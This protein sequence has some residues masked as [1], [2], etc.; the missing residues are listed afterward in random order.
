MT[1]IEAVIGRTLEREDRVGVPH[2][3]V[4]QLQ[5]RYVEETIDE[6][7][8]PPADL[9]EL[10]FVDNMGHA[11]LILVDYDG[12]LWAPLYAMRGGAAGTCREARPPAPG[13]LR[14]AHVAELERAR[15]TKGGDPDGTDG[16]RGV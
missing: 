14:A 8:L 16:T 2:F 6:E 13:K 4:G 7:E 3:K 10:S 1:P 15:T 9:F 11:W 12:G 5:A